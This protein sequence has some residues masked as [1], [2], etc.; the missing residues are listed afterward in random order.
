MPITRL[1]QLLE[2]AARGPRKRLV[3][4]F[5]N[6][7]HTI[8]AIANAVGKGLVEAT[9]VGD[10]VLIR[11]HCVE[12]GIGENRF[13]ILHEPNDVRAAT[14]AVEL[15]RRGQGQFL[16]KGALTTE[17]LLRAILD[18]DAGLVAPGAVLS[19]VSLM[20]SPN[21]PKLQVISDPAVLLCPNLTQK[22]AITNYVIE[23]ARLLGIEKP[24]IAI[25]G[26]TEQVNPK[27][28]SMVDAAVI[29][30]MADR[31]QIKHAFVDGPMAL[32]VAID[33][34]SA[35]AKGVGGDV[36]GDADGLVFPNIDAGNIFYK[37][38]TKLGGAEVAGMVVGARVPCVVSSRGDSSL[39]KLYS[40][41][42]AALA[43]SAS[44]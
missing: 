26:I 18:K 13:E 43:A 27:L 15:V 5:A 37:A 21:Y 32:D 44:K 42:L 25:L 8:E 1:V 39:S 9:L 10:E 34:E 12:Q 14:K 6:D 28:Q 7:V 33:P 11:K 3:A 31:G 36:A 2:A 40:I 19:H 17:A 16:M 41:A 29:S 24:K 23:T 4:A 30:K 35:R 38:C 20:E 22:I